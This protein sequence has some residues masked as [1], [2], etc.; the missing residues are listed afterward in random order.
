MPPSLEIH[1]HCNKRLHYPHN[2]HINST[3]SKNSKYP[4]QNELLR[5]P[6]ST[7]SSANS[8][9]TGSRATE[10]RNLYQQKESRPRTMKTVKS[11][12][13]TSAPRRLF[14]ETVA[15]PLMRRAIVVTANILFFLRRALGALS[16]SAT[17]KVLRGVTC[18][19]CCC[20]P[21]GTGSAASCGEEAF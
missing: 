10:K 6:P 16:S 18:C 1:R 20:S 5:T 4:H 19:C 2:L 11:R 7:T 17:I 14:D 9:K 21:R 15:R 13:K 3:A 12:E 8:K